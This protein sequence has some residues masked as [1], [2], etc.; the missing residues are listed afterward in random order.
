VIDFVTQ[1]SKRLSSFALP[2]CA[3]GIARR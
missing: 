1:R 3:R 2:T